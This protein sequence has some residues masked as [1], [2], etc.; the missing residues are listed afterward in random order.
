M[1]YMLLIIEPRG[2]RT[3]RSTE[4]G[5]AAYA[6]M[7]AFGKGLAARGLL[8]GSNSLRSDHD[9]VR[10]QVRDGRRALVD[11][12]F[13]ES[14]EMIGGYFLLACDDR[15][16]ALEIAAACPAAAWATVEVREIAPCH[17]G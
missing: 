16:Q 4:E 9:A 13:A 11:G 17:A 2:Q 10:V 3:E 6:Q 12:P 14:K 8:Q 1:P 7:V 5:Q 15:E